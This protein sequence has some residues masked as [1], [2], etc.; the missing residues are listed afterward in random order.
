MNM[1]AARIVLAVAMAAAF[2]AGAQALYKCVADGKTSY[3][4][5]PCPTRALQ[6]EIAAP[7][8]MP[9][10]EASSEADKP[11]APG[12]PAGTPAGDIELVIDTFVGYTVC[13]EADPG[14]GARHAYGFDGWKE[15]NAA[16]VQRFNQDPEG[17]R[18]MQDR[19]QAERHRQ[20]AD[21]DAARAARIQTCVRIAGRVKPVRPQP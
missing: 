14:F 20:Q 8:P 11:K 4:A 10:R 15:R 19:L 6:S 13:S 7:R 5:E 21:P 17:P 1:P 3:Q 12:A 18:R 16:L 9:A 2:P